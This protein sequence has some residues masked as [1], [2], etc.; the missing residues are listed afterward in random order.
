M[1][2]VLPKL[3]NVGRS[4]LEDEFVPTSRL[5]LLDVTTSTRNYTATSAT[6][7][8]ATSR[9]YLCKRHFRFR[10]TT[11]ASF[12]RRRTSTV[13]VEQ[14]RAQERLHHQPGREL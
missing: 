11:N 1:N 10:R 7:R 13:S 14:D 6:G 2:M 9:R 12:P 4:Q 3:V 8:R 5:Q